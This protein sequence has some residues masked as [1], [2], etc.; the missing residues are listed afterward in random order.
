MPGNDGNGVGVSEFI[1][2]WV[3]G[4]GLAKGVDDGGATVGGED[5]LLSSVA[6]GFGIVGGVR[7]E[8]RNTI[9]VIEQVPK[10][11][12][13]PR[14]FGMAYT[15]LFHPVPSST[16]YQMNVAIHWVRVSVNV[17]SDDR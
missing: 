5:D 12:G 13:S 16:G 6:V 1:E 8:A 14:Q 9:K 4:I 3:I 17:K 11:A 7:I 15:V 2:G 10:Q